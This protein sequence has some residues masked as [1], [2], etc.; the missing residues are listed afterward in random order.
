M[1]EV[2]TSTPPLSARVTTVI[3]AM[4]PIPLVYARYIPQTRT[5]TRPSPA[6]Y[7]LLHILI[8]GDGQRGG[9]GNIASAHIPPN[10]GAPHD[11]TVIPEPA[12]RPT[13]ADVDFHV[14]VCH[15]RTITPSPPWWCRC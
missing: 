4:V 14:G 7:I 9:A 2:D 3:K 8:V 15:L 12:M 11:A 10:S 5:L 6:P 13:S 1:N